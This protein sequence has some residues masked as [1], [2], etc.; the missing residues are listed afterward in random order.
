MEIGSSAVKAAI[1]R[2]KSARTTL[3]SWEYVLESQV[4]L[5]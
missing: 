2:L 1:E 4:H 3:V 5:L